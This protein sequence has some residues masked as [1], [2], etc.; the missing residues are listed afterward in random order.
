[1]GVYL[2]DRCV[3]VGLC[4]FRTVPLDPTRDC[5][6]TL[7]GGKP[8]LFSAFGGRMDST[9]MGAAGFDDENYGH[10]GS[11]RITRAASYCHCAWYCLVYR[12]AQKSPAEE[13]IWS[14]L[15]F[16]DVR[17]ET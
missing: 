12:L 14:E 2:P 10:G 4:R 6:P 5:Y 7:P 17:F 13:Q 1:M 8:I 9:G 16:V 15:P 3:A 11:K